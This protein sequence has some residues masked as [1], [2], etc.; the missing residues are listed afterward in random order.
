MSITTDTVR[1]VATLARLDLPPEETQAYAEQLS[2]IL[3]LMEQL[4]SIPTE[5]VK[6]MSHAVDLTLPLRDDKVVNTDQREIMLANAPDSE[7]GCFRV[8]KIIE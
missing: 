7:E 3:S 8:P 5:G 4:Q 2:R 6:P 1:H